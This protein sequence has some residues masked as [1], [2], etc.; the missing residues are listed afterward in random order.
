MI[1][2]F[3]RRLQREEGKSMDEQQLLRTRKRG[4]EKSEKDRPGGT[5]IWRRQ[6]FKERL[7]NDAP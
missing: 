4:I 5:R 1:R 6:N 2:S 7:T 3:V